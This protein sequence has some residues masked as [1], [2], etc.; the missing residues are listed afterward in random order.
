MHRESILRG[1]SD[2]DIAEDKRTAVAA[3]NLYGDEL[4]ILK[5]VFLGILGGG[6][7]MS[8]SGDNALFELNLAAGA[9]ELAGAAARDISALSDGSVNAD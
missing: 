6:V 3:V 4:L 2:D 1:N 8:L 5:A 9:Y 7:D